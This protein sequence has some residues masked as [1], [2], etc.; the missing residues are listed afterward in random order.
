MRL[1]WQWFLGGKKMFWLSIVVF[2]IFIVGF[3]DTYIID[4]TARIYTI[5][6]N[7]ETSSIKSISENYIHELGIEIDKPIEYHFVK[8]K[9]NARD[10]STK[11]EITLGTFH[12]WNDTY[13]IDISIDLYKTTSLNETVVH[14]TRHLIVDY[15][16]DKKIVNLTKYTEEIAEGN[17]EYYNAMFDSGVYL[18]KLK[19]IN[20]GGINYD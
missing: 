4:L 9:N 19:Q 16:N 2:I 18:L 7:V 20:N 17:N 3:I 15:L 12:E 8:Y 6:Q 11:G 10:A 13:Y 5:R 14:E 1:K